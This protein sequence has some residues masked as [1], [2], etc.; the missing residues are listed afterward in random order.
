M[1][2]L[3]THSAAERGTMLL[4]NGIGHGKPVRICFI[5]RQARDKVEK[6]KTYLGYLE[7]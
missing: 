4:V 3:N 5:V 1:A 7:P 2:L 6:I